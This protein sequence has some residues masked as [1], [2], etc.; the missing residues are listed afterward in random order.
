MKI[1]YL[2]AFFVL[3]MIMGSQHFASANSPD[4]IRLPASIHKFSSPL[5]YGLGMIF[6]SENDRITYE[7]EAYLRL[8]FAKKVAL[9]SNLSGKS[10]KQSLHIDLHTHKALG[11]PYTHYFGAGI[12]NAGW[13]PTTDPVETAI[14]G[15]Y[16]NY[17]VEYQSL[18]FHFGI[19]ENKNTLQE[20]ILGLFGVEHLTEFGNVVLEWSGM[21]ISFGFTALI[22]NKNKAYVGFTPNNSDGNRRKQLLSVGYAWLENHFFEDH[23]DRNWN[24]PQRLKQ[25]EFNKTEAD[26][27]VQDALERMERGLDL[28][29]KGY[30]PLAKIELEKVIEIFPTPTSYSRLGSI[31]YKLKEYDEALS[32]WKKAYSLDPSNEEIKNMIDFVEKIRTPENEESE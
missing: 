18:V 5:E 1:K 22:N 14:I 7:A 17:A 11:S 9:N 12:K 10:L 15:A 23:R 6:G 24:K 25:N 8:I 30:Y 16:V 28:Y 27:K 13:Y 3:L 2:A 20:E 31:H 19:A 26:T 4:M 29:L 32:Y 21:N